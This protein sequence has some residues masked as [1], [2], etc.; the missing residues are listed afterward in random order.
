MEFTDAHI[1]NDI[2][3]DMK[4]IPDDIRIPAPRF[5]FEDA[6]KTIE[7]REKLLEELGARDFLF[8]ENL[9]IFPIMSQEEAIKIIQLNERGRQGKMRA[10]Y[11]A[12]VR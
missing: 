3:S 1:Y 4:L 11:M 12:D 5:I 10:K 2:L 9:D 6:E 7:E 8:G